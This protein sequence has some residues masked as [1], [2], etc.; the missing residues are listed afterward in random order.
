[1][2][3][4]V[5]FKIFGVSLLMSLLIAPLRGGYVTIGSLDGFHISSIVGFIIYFI[6]TFYCLAKVRDKLST[7]L[8]L[9]SLLVGLNAIT[10]PIRIMNFQGTLGSALECLIHISAVLWGYVFYKSKRHLRVLT[11]TISIIW[12]FWFS[13]AGYKMW[14]HKLS[15]GTFTGK[16]D[17]GTNFDIQFQT[18]SGD[19]L[20]LVDFKGKYLL[21]DCWYTYCGICY[22]KMPELQK[23]Y[24]KYAGNNEIK[25]YGMHS[26]MKGDRD[27]NRTP[28]NCSTGTQI[29]ENEGY[30]YPCLAIDIENPVLKELGINF[31][32]TVLL[33][34]RDS[35]LIF[36]G[37]IEN[38]GDFIDK[39]LN[40]K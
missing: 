15:Y 9:V 2:K 8:I 12:C 36:R 3:K 21:L 6:M 38:A 28:E 19:T 29:L 25:I 40:Y 7:T 14:I 10:L 1:M 37:G 32:P 26:F 39:K 18:S 4:K 22:K 31:Y 20:S 24:D 27:R 16:I 33:F 30:K 5:F 35:K 34:D 23:L 11:L 13:I 17:A